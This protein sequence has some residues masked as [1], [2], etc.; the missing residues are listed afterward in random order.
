MN[1]I[2]LLTVNSIMKAIYRAKTEGI[3]TNRKSK[4]YNILFEGE[5]FPPKYIV[6][7]AIKIDQNINLTPEDINGGLELNKVLRI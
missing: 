2:K 3:P 4:T 6:M 1:P 5:I 7:L